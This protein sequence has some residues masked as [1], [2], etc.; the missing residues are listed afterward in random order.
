MAKTP[1]EIARELAAAG[2]NV[3]PAGVGKKAPLVSWARFQT[4][5]T[6]PKLSQWFGGG[7]R[8]YWVATGQISSVLVLDCDSGP[9]E[10]Y[11][12]ERLRDYTDV[13]D[14][15]NH[16]HILDRTTTAK[17]RQGHHYWFRLPANTPVAS[18]SYHKGDV[19]FDV[20]ADGTGV[21]VPPSVHESGHVYEWVR[22][23]EAMVD[24]V[25]ELRGPEK[26]MAAEAS[27]GG[28]GPRS[29][30]THLLES[31]P[32]HGKRN[33]WFTKVCGHYAFQFRDREDA[34]QFHVR[35]AYANMPDQHDA[36]EA[37]KTIKSVWAKE[38]RKDEDGVLQ[39]GPA[40][41]YLVPGERCLLTPVQREVNEQKVVSLEEWADFDIRAV[42]VVE[43]DADP[44]VY[45]VAIYRKRQGDQRADLLPSKVIADGKALAA[46]LANHGVS[47]LAPTGKQL[48]G[49]ARDSAR[50]LRYIE[51][52]DPPH[53]KT[54]PCLGWHGE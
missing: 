49:A 9:A 30:L 18:W 50:L 21:I 14:E 28:D 13:D 33:D 36:E 42:G 4:E 44:R 22:G 39:A 5:R 46:W 41:G 16:T 51:H 6:E 27:G 31:P 12:R 34:Y 19:Q 29:M 38:Q 54:V 11:W 10:E 23:L 37:E 25:P 17:T 32:E 47:I 3:L 2:L 48:A 40:N 20:R 7:D 43:S 1:L 24:L 52:Q 8:N 15:G 45:D 53:F 26:S 35:Q